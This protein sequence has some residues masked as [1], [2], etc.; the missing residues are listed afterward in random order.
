MGLCT[1]H[2][3]TLPWLPG[4]VRKSREASRDIESSSLRAPWKEFAAA[5]PLPGDIAAQGGR[6]RLRGVGKERAYA[7][8]DLGEL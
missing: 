6:G 8:K 7:R 4:R 1:G 2:A 3:P 5:L